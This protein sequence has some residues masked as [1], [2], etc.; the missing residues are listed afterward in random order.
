MMEA[1]LVGDEGQAA[2]ATAPPSNESDAHDSGAALNGAGSGSAP[3]GHAESSSLSP[4]HA[5]ESGQAGDGG[6]GERS[7]RVERVDLPADD[8]YVPPHV[9]ANTPSTNAHFALR[10]SHNLCEL[11]TMPQS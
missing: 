10:A 1:S 5:S 4:A 6:G 8:D 3:P 9:S 7:A 2:S 11:A